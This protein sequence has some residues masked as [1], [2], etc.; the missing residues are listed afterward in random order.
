M[1]QEQRDTITKGG[2]SLTFTLW[3]WATIGPP[4]LIGLVVSAAFAEWW[5]E[6]SLAKMLPV[7]L[8]GGAVM[9]AVSPIGTLIWRWKFKEQILEPLR[10]LGGTMTQ[11]ADG[12]LRLRADIRRNDEIGL[13]AQDCNHLI[14]SLAGIASNVR[15][16]AESVSASLS[17]SGLVL[18][19]PSDLPPCC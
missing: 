8:F 2:L 17:A 10:D 3:T 11:A 1:A 6:L 12:D 16:S 7:I 9:V 13:L 15:R 5:L 14:G 18:A 4:V 19:V